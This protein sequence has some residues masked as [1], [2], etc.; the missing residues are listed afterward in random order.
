VSIELPAASFLVFMFAVV[1]ATAWLSFAPPFSSGAIPS[2]VRFGLAAALGLAVTPQLAAAPAGGGMPFGT[3]V[4]ALGTGAF[5]SEMVVQVVVGSLLGFMTSIFLSVLMGAGSLTDATSGLSAATAFDPISGQVNPVTANTYNQIAT[6]L[7]F[8]T[9]GDLVI[10][11]GFMTSFQAVG[12]SSRAMGLIGPAL[13][14]EIGYFFEASLEIAAPVM[15]CMFLAYVAMGL[16]T[17]S[18]PQLNVMSLGFG[19]NIALAFVV[20]AACLPLMPGA[21]NTL[22]DHVVADTLGLLGI[23]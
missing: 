23:R 13:M 1:R 14:S 9:G 12:L 21:V 22:V 2:L 5:I 6:T 8:A 16:L 19:I 11:K 15:A 18:A 4:M 3:V 10:V 7:L 20:I 17:R